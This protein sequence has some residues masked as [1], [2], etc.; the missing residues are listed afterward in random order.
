M[1][2]KR[3]M[4][5]LHLWIG[6][7]GAVVFFFICITGSVFVFADEIMDFSN[8]KFASVSETHDE[9]MPIEQMIDSVQKVYPKHRL[10]Y[11]TAQKDTNTS[12]KFILVSR[13]GL[14]DVFVNPYNAQI[15][16]QSRVVQFFYII[17]HLHSMLLWHGPGGW[18]IKIATILFLITLVSG[19]VIWWPKRNKKNAVKNAFT[20][21]KGLPL[22]RKMFD[23]HRVWGF[24]G[25]GILLLLT[26]TGLIIAFAPLSN[27]VSKAVGGNPDLDF[28]QAY[29]ADSTRTMADF[30][31][32][33]KRYL[34]QPD[35]EKVQVSYFFTDKSSAVRLLTGTNVGIITNNGSTHMINQYS[36]EEIVDKALV[37]NLETTNMLLRLHTGKYFGWLGLILTFLAGLLGAFLSVSGV[38]LWVIRTW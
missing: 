21:K 10:I 16:G 38:W 9:W 33:L 34:N 7:P 17:A 2:I 32:V 37:R 1:T 29:P 36:G 23:W 12:F 22:R 14:L 28:V 20:Y 13:E 24:Y 6:L 11:I 15:M 35:V 31:P 25:L 19:L 4:N 5:R 8:R 18:I 3:L 26:V 27:A 30:R